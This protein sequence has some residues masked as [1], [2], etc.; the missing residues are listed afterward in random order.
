MRARW[1][2]FACAIAD[3]GVHEIVIG[4]ASTFCRLCWRA[5]EHEDGALYRAW[6]QYV[7]EALRALPLS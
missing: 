4:T 3:D 5:I 1:P 7:D 2:G 6:S